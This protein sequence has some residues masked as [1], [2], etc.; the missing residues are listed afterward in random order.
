MFVQEENP[1]VVFALP[2]RKKQDSHRIY[3]FQS[4]IYIKVGGGFKNDFKDK[5]IL[6]SLGKRSTSGD[7]G[8]PTPP[9]HDWGFSGRSKNDPWWQPNPSKASMTPAN[10]FAG[11]QTTQKEA[12]LDQK[13]K[14]KNEALS[15]QPADK[16]EVFIGFYLREKL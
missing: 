13:K 6:W 8:H 10:M 3:D 11:L 5:E 9:E 4:L 7:R 14:T 15:R 1:Y 12:L 16:Y 2:K